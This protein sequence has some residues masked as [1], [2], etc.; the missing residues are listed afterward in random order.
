[1]KGLVAS[2]GVHEQP[3]F[4]RIP[5]FYLH[6]RSANDAAA[7][8]FFVLTRSGTVPPQNTQFY[9]ASFPTSFKILHFIPRRCQRGPKP[10]ILTLSGS[11]E[12]RN[13]QFHHSTVPTCLKIWNFTPRRFQRGFKSRILP[14]SGSN[15]GQN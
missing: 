5:N 15:A 13:F 10:G 7:P 8:K 6:L 9:L 1:M 2:G 14:L 4:S 11:N 3:Q 12:V